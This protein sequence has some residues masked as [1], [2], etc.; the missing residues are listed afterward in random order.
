M[1]EHQGTSDMALRAPR[2]SH[3]KDRLWVQVA[4]KEEKWEQQRKRSIE[5]VGRYRDGNRDR[6]ASAM[7]RCGSRS[8]RE[9]S[10]DGTG[11]PVAGRTS[12]RGQG[13]SATAE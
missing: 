13:G 4:S 2:G 6:Q 10:G 5:D 1:L 11:A 8:E 12:R 9:A 7:S 3:P